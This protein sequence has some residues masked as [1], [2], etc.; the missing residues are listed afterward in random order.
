MALEPCSHGEL[1]PPVAI[2]RAESVKRSGKIQFKCGDLETVV[3]IKLL[4]QE[5]DDLLVEKILNPHGRS[6]SG[7]DSSSE[8][9]VKALECLLKS[10]LDGNE[11]EEGLFWERG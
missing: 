10:S 1:H 6:D 5:L 7:S 8:P 9:L 4:R 3:L 11:N 2:P